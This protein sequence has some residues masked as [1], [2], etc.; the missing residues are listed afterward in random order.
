MNYNKVLFEDANTGEVI[1]ED[2][3]LANHAESFARFGE[4]S[5]WQ[6]ITKVIQERIKTLQLELETLGREVN[7]ATG[8]VF[9]PTTADF[10][11]IQGEIFAWRVLLDLPENLARNL[12]ADYKE[13]ENG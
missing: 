3:V 13:Q 5:V 2:L 8:E 7:E 4:N 6:D 10:A 11:F 1:Q 12:M 9:V